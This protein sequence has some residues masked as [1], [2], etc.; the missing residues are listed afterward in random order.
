M[1]FPKIVYGTCPRCGDKAADDTTPNANYDGTP[2]SESDIQAGNGVI[3]E[4]YGDEY[5]CHMCKK[6]IQADEESFIIAE[7]ISE[8]QNFRDRVGFTN[9]IT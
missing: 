8:D 4:L 2:N 6:R 7:E 9:T 3:L 5:I 1:S